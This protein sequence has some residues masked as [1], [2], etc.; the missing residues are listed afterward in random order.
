[1]IQEGIRC[2]CNCSHFTSIWT[3]RIHCT[4]LILI[5][6]IA[7]PNMDSFMDLLVQLWSS[8]AL[9]FWNVQCLPCNRLQTYTWWSSTIIILLSMIF[10]LFYSNVGNN[11]CDDNK[12]DALKSSQDFSSVVLKEM[13]LTL[14]NDVG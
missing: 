14:L 2:R 11:K 7:C 1:M 13:P 8:F 6:Y 10:K 12:C 9:S 4:L 3:R 5:K